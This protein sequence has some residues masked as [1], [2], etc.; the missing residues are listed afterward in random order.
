MSHRE[1]DRPAFARRRIPAGRYGR[2]EEIAYIIGTLTAVD[3]SFING[4]VIPVDGGMTAQT[5]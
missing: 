4:A 3:A 2:P 1:A 5:R